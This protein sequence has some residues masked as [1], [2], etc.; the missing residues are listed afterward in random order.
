MYGCNKKPIFSS[1]L[2]CLSRG[3]RSAA[4]GAGQSCLAPAM[5]AAGPRGPKEEEDESSHMEGG[6][7]A[8]RGRMKGK[9]RARQ[10]LLQG[11]A[12]G[13]EKQASLVLMTE[14]VFLNVHVEG[15][16]EWLIFLETEAWPSRISRGSSFRSAR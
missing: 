11:P 13:L 12:S 16:V 3:A 5:A 15:E 6:A 4:A 2:A 7:S 10:W 1:L 14:A 8:W 9:S